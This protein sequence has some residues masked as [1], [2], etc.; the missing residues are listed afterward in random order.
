MV[1]KPA[2]YIDDNIANDFKHI[3]KPLFPIAPIAHQKT[4]PTKARLG[5]L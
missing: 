3:T 5:R 1:N 4:S 2:L